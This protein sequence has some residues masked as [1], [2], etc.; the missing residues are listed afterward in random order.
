MRRVNVGAVK[1][2]RV[3]TIACISRATS[4]LGV[5]FPSLISA[6]QNYV[7]KHLARVWGTP[8]KLAWTMIFV[9]TADDI[10]NL[11]EDLKENLWHTPRKWLPT[12]LFKG[13]PIALVFAKAVLAGPS[14][15]SD[16]ARISLAASHE[17][18]EMLIDPGNN[19]WC[20]RGK[21]TLY[22]YEVCDALVA[23]HFPVK[24][25]AMSNF[26]FPLFLKH[27]TS[28]IRCNSIT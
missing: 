7:D 14:R 9:D 27:S 26:V 5:D 24:G 15:L 18:A 16:R 21:G 20:G 12:I 17:L 1:P 11:R 2:G 6:L 23:K 4:G 13:H 22:A 8:A 10:R 25:L 19:L 3:P 28:V